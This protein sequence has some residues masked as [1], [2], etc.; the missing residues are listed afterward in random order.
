MT[1]DEIRALFESF[2]TALESKLSD[3][4]FDVER[5]YNHGEHEAAILGALMRA[6]FEGVP[7]SDE[8]IDRA[9]PLFPRGGEHDMFVYAVNKIRSNA[10]V[11][12]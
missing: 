12:A 5:L 8:L 11:T 10:P 3:F 2:R 6:A 1:D 7:V 4:Q 9:E